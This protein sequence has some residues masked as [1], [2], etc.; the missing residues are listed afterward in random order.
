MTTSAIPRLRVLVASLAP[1]FLF[2]MLV[3]MS[4][5]NLHLQE[6]LRETVQLTVVSGLL[7]KVQDLLGEGLVGLGPCGGGVVG[8]V[9]GGY[10]WIR[11]KIIRV[12]CFGSPV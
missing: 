12:H 1:F 6:E 4:I 7:D 11:W 10:S 8:H 3:F 9:E 5:G 2:V